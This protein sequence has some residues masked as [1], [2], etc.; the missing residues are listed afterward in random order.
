MSMIF[1][2]V[3]GPRVP[4]FVQESRPPVPDGTAEPFRA[5]ITPFGVKSYIL[6]SILSLCSTVRTRM[7]SRHPADR[8]V[9]P[10]PFSPVP[11]PSPKAVQSL[12][13]AA[14]AVRQSTRSKTSAERLMLYIRM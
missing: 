7:S 4:R 12:G 1:T 5:I 11:Y 2:P 14:A 9:A 3:F 8:R 10:T 6:T 13:N